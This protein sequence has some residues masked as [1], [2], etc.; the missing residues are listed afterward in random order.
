MSDRSGSR[1]RFFA[2]FTLRRAFMSVGLLLYCLAL[3]LAFDF[4]YST[5]T[6]GEETKRNPR[7]RQ[8]RL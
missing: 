5:L 2:Y 7:D 8:R 6:R 4:A 3:L 1:L